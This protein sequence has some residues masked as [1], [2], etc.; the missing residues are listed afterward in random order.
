MGGCAMKR[1]HCD[2]SVWHVFARGARRLHLFH[3]DEDF[4]KFTV[5]LAFAVKKTGCALWAFALMNNHYHLVLRGSS[6]QLAACMHRLNLLYSA[7]HNTRYALDGHTFDAPYHAYR[8]VTPLLTLRC[9]AYV[10][11]NPVKAGLCPKP[12]D[13]A[14]SC[15]RCYAGLPGSPI[16]VEPSEVLSMLGFEPKAGWARFSQAMD[17][18]ARRPGRASSGKLTMVEVHSEQFECLLDYAKEHQ[19]QLFGEDPA[20][21]AMYWGR[22]CGI[23]PRAMAKAVG[24]ENTPLFRQSIRRFATRVLNNPALRDRLA[25]P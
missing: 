6:A 25:P 4:L 11:M 22:Q 2:T 12:E 8:Q 16:R 9:L 19:D 14:W 3:D 5:F 1:L 18:E 23:A 10:F 21:V 17:R 7:Y 13:W 15:F 24:V 20:M